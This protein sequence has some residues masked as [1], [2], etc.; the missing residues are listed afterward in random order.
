MTLKVS[1]CLRCHLQ[2]HNLT[3]SELRGTISRLY[4]KRASTWHTDT[5][6][7]MIHMIMETRLQLHSMCGLDTG[8]MQ[9]SGTYIPADQTSWTGPIQ[10]LENII[11][12]LPYCHVLSLLIVYL[13]PL[14][15]KLR[16]CCQ[17]WQFRVH[18]ESVWATTFWLEHARGDGA[19]KVFWRHEHLPIPVLIVHL[20]S[21]KVPKYLV[22]RGVGSNTILIFYHLQIYNINWCLFLQQV[23]FKKQSVIKRYYF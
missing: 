16:R 14:T 17:F 2:H 13:K 20:Q 21:C 3:Q 7:G 8:D 12:V 23:S 11:N 19:D 15:L 4:T 9:G 5:C 10:D 1:E 22:W 18:N 6:I